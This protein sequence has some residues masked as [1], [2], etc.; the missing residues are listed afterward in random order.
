MGASIT[1]LMET[2]HPHTEKQQAQKV[3]ASNCLFELLLGSKLARVATLLL[4]AV[5]SARGQAGIAL[6]ANHLFAVEGLG[7]RCK[8]GVN[9]TTTQTKH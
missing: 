7:K 2:A 9:N 1:S 5:L 4:A 6:A 8:S 3:L